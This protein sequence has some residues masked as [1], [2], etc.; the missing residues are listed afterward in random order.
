MASL[1]A[2]ADELQGNSF[3]MAGPSEFFAVVSGGDGPPEDIEFPGGRHVDQDGNFEFRNVPVGSHLLTGTCMV[4]KQRYSTRMPIQLEPAGL[5]NLELRPVGPSTITG[6]L[7]LE[8]ESNSKLSDTRVWVAQPGSE[9]LFFSGGP[10]SVSGYGKTAEDGTFSFHDLAP[11]VYHINVKPPKDLYVKSVTWE[12]R[13]VRESGVDLKAGGM[14]AALQVVLTANGGSI[15]G[16]VENGAGATV[17]LI[18]SDPEAAR[19][20]A[21]TAIV[22]PDG[23]FAF[24]LVAPGRYKLFAWEHVDAN[25]AM[26]DAEFRK[27]FE[28]KGQTVDVAEK[29]KSTVQLELIP[30]AEK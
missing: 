14:S 5:E 24:P 1:E 22:G 26:Y 29:Q 27:P 19:T 28:G 12:G 15:E 4:G 11:D 20:M 30:S 6:Q 3:D 17:T 10:D 23:H 16:S 7:R 9:M 25:A 13:D 21:E 18:P 8:G 2:G